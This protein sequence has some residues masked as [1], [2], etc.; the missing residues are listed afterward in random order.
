M[1]PPPVGF[2]GEASP[3]S[4]VTDGIN[5]GG[6]PRRLWVLFGVMT[7]GMWRQ[8]PRVE[9]EE[10]MLA[11]AMELFT[12]R[13][14]ANVS[15]DAIAE[16]TGIT[17]PLIYSYFGSKQN[18]YATCIRRFLEPLVGLLIDAV[19]VRL[20]PERRMWEGALVS[21]RWVGENRDG[22]NRFCLEPVAHG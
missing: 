20:S 6:N 1:A 16:R 12:E 19:D 10:Q 9:R 5:T 18:L 14:F 13:G 7:Q 21:F 15:M 17:K 11:A 2:P 3:S 4:L 8:V 22:W